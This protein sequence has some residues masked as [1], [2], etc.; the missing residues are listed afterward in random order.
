MTIYE[1]L[2]ITTPSVLN[3]LLSLP[4]TSIGAY[5][6]NL[7]LFDSKLNAFKQLGPL[8]HLKSLSINNCV[9]PTVLYKIT[10]LRLL[11][12]RTTILGVRRLLR[13]YHFIYMLK[14]G[15]LNSR[16]R[17]FLA[18]ICQ[19]PHGFFFRLRALKEN[20]LEPD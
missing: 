6:G 17:H 7:G 14:K 5:E 19:R 1:C 9:T 13:L 11:M 2:P 4:N 20:R 8:I 3:K 16:T 15:F 10:S 12:R 18:L